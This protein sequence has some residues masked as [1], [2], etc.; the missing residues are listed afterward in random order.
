MEDTLD[1]NE[2]ID[3]VEE[4]ELDFVSV[5][6]PTIQTPESENRPEQE[7]GVEGEKNIKQEK[8]E[9]KEDPL[10]QR[11][12]ETRGATGESSKLE[13][14]KTISAESM[15]E[16]IVNSGLSREQQME[17]LERLD[18]ILIN[19]KQAHMFPDFIKETADTKTTYF[20][21]LKADD[22]G[23]VRTLIVSV[24]EKIEK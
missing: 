14:D 16:N 1:L 23:N 7:V 4:T 10:M 15:R 11:I 6:E 19:P 2:G 18:N 3:G 13:I 5:F 9:E 12:T 22:E 24:E 21:A 20:A 8:P 17:E